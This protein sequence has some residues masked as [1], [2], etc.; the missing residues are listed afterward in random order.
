MN[1]SDFLIIYLA[2]GAPF[3][4]YYFFQNRKTLHQNRLTLNSF[5]TMTVWIPYAFKMLQEFIRNQLLIYK[6]ERLSK[7]DSTR[8]RELDA[9]EKAVAQILLAENINVSLFDFR[10][11]FQRYAGLTL[12]LKGVSETEITDSE[13][14]LFRVAKTEN[15]DL[16]AKCLRRR[17]LNR[18]KFHQTLS[19]TDIIKMFGAINAAIGQSDHFKL[20]VI[21]FFELLDDEGA[22][23]A[24]SEI[25]K[26]SSQTEDD[27]A[28]RYTENELWK[29]REEKRRSANQTALSLKAMSATAIRKRE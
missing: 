8:K 7:F 26:S 20:Q 16:G 6:L 24:I 5:L 12:A 28:V 11:T 18:L 22:K 14:E 1:F 23:G 29:P 13:K 10:E 27:Y 15:V 17:N 25:F 19:R 3:G 9:V 2:C 4:V 21:K